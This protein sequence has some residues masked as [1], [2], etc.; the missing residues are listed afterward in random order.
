MFKYIVSGLLFLLNYHAQ[1]VFSQPYNCEVVNFS[2]FYEMKSGLLTKTDSIFIQINNRSGEGFTN[3]KIPYSKSEK[4][5]DLSAWLEDQNGQI[6]RKLKNSDITDR[7]AISDYSL[8]TDDFVKT[9]SLKHNIYPYRIVYTYRKTYKQFITI[10][11]VPILDKSIPTLKAKLT[12][13]VPKGFPFMKYY[14]NMSDPKIDTLENTIRSVWLASY[15]KPIK[16]EI[17]SITEDEILPYVMITPVYFTYGVDGNA[18]DWTSFGNWNYRLI[19][20]LGELPD[21]E[22]QKISQLIRGITDKREIVKIL[23]HYLQDRTRYVNVSIDI[24]GLKPYPASYVAQNKYG[25]C[26]ALSNYMKALLNFAGIQSFYTTINRDKTPG[27][28]VEQMPGPQYF[29]HVILTVPLDKDTL[30]L[31]NTSNSNPFA[32]IGTDIQGRQALLTDEHNSRLIR[33]PRLKESD[34]TITRKIDASFAEN[35]DENTELNLSF[36]GDEFEYFNQLKTELNKDEQDEL[37]RKMI[38]AGNFELQNWDL[39]RLNR[40]TARIDLLLKLIVY[41]SLKSIGEEKYFSL[42]LINIPPFSLPKERTLPVEIPFPICTLDSQTYHLPLGFEIK[43][44]PDSKI[45]STPYGLYELT[46]ASNGS[47][48]KVVKKF[49]LNAGNYPLNQ[50]PDFYKFIDSANELEHTKIII[51]KKY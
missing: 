35:G 23:Y 15:L 40:D 18:A 19:K 38:H 27:E 43:S 21:S 45:I 30:W 2:S 11:W 13:L 48:I 46:C 3:I 41:K 10:P 51:K 28:I 37:I 50:Y 8:Y 47:I 32:Y 9:F 22:K 39:K 31:E 25:D 42:F 20:D 26:K 29:N 6:I 4:I 33:M 36:K 44:L 7:N 24:G 1:S 16:A 14:K 34:I 12:L 5:S 49:K 17:F